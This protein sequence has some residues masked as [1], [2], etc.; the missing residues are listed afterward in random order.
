[1][2]KS[3]SMRAAGALLV[4]TLLSTSAVSGT[5]AKYVTSDS[6][7]DTARVA[8]FGVVVAASGSLF[9]ETYIDEP[10]EVVINSLRPEPQISIHSHLKIP[11]MFRWIIT[12]ICRRG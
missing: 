3:K 2:K 7:S 9:S 5:Y 4:A 6:G 1:M 8:K 10:E 12:W 11:A